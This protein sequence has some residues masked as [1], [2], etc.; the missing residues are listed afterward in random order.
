MNPFKYYVEIEKALEKGRLQYLSTKFLL[1]N[2]RETL[3]NRTNLERKISCEGE[4]QIKLVDITYC[5]P[6][7]KGHEVKC[8]YIGE[9]DHNDIRPCLYKEIIEKFKKYNE[10]TIH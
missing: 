2:G 9:Y 3:W 10:G 5:L 1:K 8:P 4:N 6:S 7:M